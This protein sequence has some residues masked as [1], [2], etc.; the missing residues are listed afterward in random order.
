MT[1]QAAVTPCAFPTSEPPE[2]PGSTR[3]QADA[4]LWALRGLQAAIEA[5]KLRDEEEEVVPWH[6]N[7]KKRALVAL[8]EALQPLCPDRPPSALV[9]I[10]EAIPNYL[11]RLAAM[12]LPPGTVDRT[13]DM[14]AEKCSLR[15]V[16]R[17]LL[18]FRTA[19]C[20]CAVLEGVFEPFFDDLSV[21]H[22]LQ[23]LSTVLGY[24]VAEIRLAFSASGFLNRSRM[25]ELSTRDSF[26]R[27]TGL[28]DRLQI[29]S[30][31]LEIFE[32][33]D[34]DFDRLVDI[35]VSRMEPGRLDFVDFTYLEDEWTL[36]LEYLAGSL[37]DR[38]RGANVLLHGP[39]GTGKTEF[40]R[41][42]V[43]A[44]GAAAFEV[45][46]QTFAHAILDGE[47]RRDRYLLAGEL[48]QKDESAVLIFD[49]AEDSLGE[50]HPFSRSNNSSKAALN[51]ML[52][53]NPLPTIWIVNGLQGV[54]SSVLRRFDVYIPFRNPPASVLRRQLERALPPGS[55]S[56]QWLREVAAAPNLTPAII[57]RLR[58]IALR[59][60]GKRIRQQL[61]DASLRMSEIRVKR[62]DTGPFRREFCNADPDIDV[63]CTFLEGSES[64]RLLLYGPTGTGKTALARHLAKATD[65][66]PV[67]VRSSDLLGAYVGQTERNTAQLFRRARPGEELLIFDEVEALAGDRRNAERRWEISQVSEFLNRL[68]DYEGRVIACTN[69]LDTLDTAFRRRFQM[70]AEIAE[71]TAAQRLELVGWFMEQLGLELDELTGRRVAALDQLA[72]GH[73]QNAF[74]I[75][76]HLSD[77]DA[78]GFIG[79]LESE[80]EGTSGR[81]RNR[82]GFGG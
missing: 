49:D 77:T 39:P 70:K 9:E 57:R 1:E 54:E 16:E 79:L 50:P 4:L 61:L 14:L 58:R 63:V 80:L 44:L 7:S 8:R 28:D 55:V 52:E 64:A 40:A 30:C 34:G 32:I 53:E 37:R 21:S 29:N 3:L 17:D 47:D 12:D 10:A 51:A 26:P 69:L 59:A 25:M 42:V 45:R 20:S 62:R 48:V 22:T 31:F 74:E 33:A 6:K 19:W 38:A 5:G 27:G 11:E 68:N 76:S 66:R 81:R 15:P 72:Y 75:A 41:A 36:A 43:K 78:Q 67:V 35:V 24:P 56:D 46:T 71:L 13:I 60:G 23:L 65:L 73:A 82:V 18:R 2:R